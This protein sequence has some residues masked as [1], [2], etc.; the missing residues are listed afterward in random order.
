MKRQLIITIIILVL[1]IAG[2]IVALIL[3]PPEE[4]ERGGSGGIFVTEKNNCESDTYNCADFNTQAEAQEVFDTCGPED[5]HG[6]D[7]DGNGRACESLP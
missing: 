3:S 5:V 4:K 1:I 7:R 6:L 2:I